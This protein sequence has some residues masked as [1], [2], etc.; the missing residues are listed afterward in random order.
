[1]KKIYTMEEIEEAI[2][3][4]YERNQFNERYFWSFLE[5]LK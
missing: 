2:T 3:Y 4:A 1:M 5:K